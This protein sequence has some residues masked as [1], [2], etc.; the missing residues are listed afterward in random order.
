VEVRNAAALAASAPARLSARPSG[1]EVNAAALPQKISQPSRADK[2]KVLASE[3]MLDTEQGTNVLHTQVAATSSKKSKLGMSTMSA[4]GNVAL[5]TTPL[6]QPSAMMDVE[7]VQV[8]L[9]HLDEL[10]EGDAHHVDS[11]ALLKA[12]V[13]ADGE[14]KTDLGSVMKIAVLSNGELTPVRRSKRNAIVADVDSFKRAERRVAV[15][16][17]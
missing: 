5:E 15:K 7:Q 13:V 2:A 4:T 10:T 8:S 1:K 3:T 14:T 16:N 9:G 17:L 12:G 6:S 11:V